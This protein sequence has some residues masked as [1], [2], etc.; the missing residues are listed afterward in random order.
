MTKAEKIKKLLEAI[1]EVEDDIKKLQNNIDKAKEYL[2]QDIEDIDEVYFDKVLHIEQGLK[3]IE[4][5]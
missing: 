3:H 4:L 1:Q 5:F 2:S